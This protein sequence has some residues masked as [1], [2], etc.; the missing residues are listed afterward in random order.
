LAKAGGSSLSR[1]ASDRALCEHPRCPGTFTR[2]GEHL[3]GR[4]DP[5][6]KRCRVC[7]AG[8]HWRA[9]SVRDWITN[10]DGQGQAKATP[11]ESSSL[12]DGLGLIP[13]TQERQLQEGWKHASRVDVAE[14][15]HTDPEIEAFMVGNAAGHGRRRTWERTLNGPQVQWS[16]L[17]TY[18]GMPEGSFSI[19]GDAR[20]TGAP[21]GRPTSGHLDVVEI[22]SEL[23]AAQERLAFLWPTIIGV[24][25]FRELTQRK[26]E[27]AVRAVLLAEMTNLN[28]Q[29]VADVAG[30]PSLAT[31]YRLRTDGQG[32]LRAAEFYKSF[33][34]AITVLTQQTQVLEAIERVE[35]KLDRVIA[36]CAETAARLRERFPND[37]EVAEAVDR[38]LDDVLAQPSEKAGLNQN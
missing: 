34:E 27:R 20:V 4:F 26:R 37:A 8:A 35:R 22:A 30:L 31:L 9:G 17:Q 16:D 11:L 7:G 6:T 3:P 10:L 28:M 25:R 32:L 36:D 21:P 1:V 5:K 2:K 15:A 33:M 19:E 13:L 12:W 14:T 24:G 38:F 23:L 18:H 29:A